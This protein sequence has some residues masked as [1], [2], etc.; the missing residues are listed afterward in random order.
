MSDPHHNPW[1][2][3]IRMWLAPQK[4]QCQIKEMEKADKNLKDKQEQ[5]SNEVQ[6]QRHSTRN[7][8]MLMQALGD[9]LRRANHVILL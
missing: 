9:R 1:D 6:G 8:R 2:W 3:W 7:V 4:L 5:A